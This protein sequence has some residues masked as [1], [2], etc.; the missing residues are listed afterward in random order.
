MI[1]DISTI[2]IQSR[3]ASKMGLNKR[4]NA[5]KKESLQVLTEN[6]YSIDT[7]RQD[8]DALSDFRTRFQ[9]A[10]RFLRGDQWSDLMWNDTTGEY[11]REEDYIIEQGKLPLK[12][13]II[14]PIVKS[15]SGLFRTDNGKSI[16]FST[17]P[18]S[19]KVESMLSNAL[20]Y[21]LHLNEAKEIDSRTFEYFMLSGLPIQKIGYDFIDEVGRYDVRIE[22]VDANYIFF[23]GDI[24][25]VRLTDL[26]RIGQIHDISLEEVYVNFAK[27]KA[28]KEKLEKIYS[29]VSKEEIQTMLS[30][31]YDRIENLDFYLSPDPSKC[32]VIEV[33]EK[34]AVD[35]IDYWDQADG[36]EGYWTGDIGELAMINQSRIQ[37]YSEANIPEEEWLLI[38]YEQTIGFKWFFKC[39]SPM[40][41][42]L[43]EGETPYAHGSHPFEMYPYPLISGE[44]WGL[45]E[46]II[47]QQKYLNRLITLW[48]SVIGTSSKN[49]VIFDRQS[50]EGQTPEEL[51][52]RYREVG[53]II[54]LDMKNGAKPPFTINDKMVDL[55]VNELIGMQLKWIQ[56]ISGVQPSMQGQ[57]ANSGT[58]A[59]RYA[60]EVN[61]ATLNSKDLVDSYSAFRRRRDLKVLKVLMQ[62]YKGQRFISISGEQ[63]ENLYDSEIAKDYVNALDIKV[64]Q[65]S[66]SPTYKAW[67]DDM[68]KELVM[69]QLIDLKTF[70]RHSNFPFSE[71]LLQDIEKQTEQAQQGAIS[72]QQAASNINQNYRQQPGVDPAKIDKIDG[73]VRI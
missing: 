47:D 41:H 24:K 64:G 13:N 29:S 27:T 14:R 52:A 73:L 69:N 55:G 12:Q 2:D 70:L 35:V 9:R 56:D 4:I 22:Y 43:R 39:L 34:K 46:D 61:Q 42:V 20:Q 65:S 50:L 36:T 54:V 71:S 21:A 66:D 51:G 1:T 38:H 23:N 28:D 57:Q 26:R 63:G 25:D 5:I 67:V 31:T 49:T 32:R 15:L 6:I 40:G 44:V 33:W 19:G 37:K 10:T 7:Y 48:D 17:R 62:Y 8:W 16:V 68:L 11:I 3:T 18:N 59:N 60:M 53:G 58:P 45:V 72:P 30:L